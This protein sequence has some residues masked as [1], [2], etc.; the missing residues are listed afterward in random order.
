MKLLFTF[1]ALMSVLKMATAQTENTISINDM[2]KLGFAKYDSS[3]VGRKSGDVYVHRVFTLNTESKTDTV[4]AYVIHFLRPLENKLKNYQM[5][6][7][8]DDDYS[9]AG[10]SWV[11]DSIVSVTLVNP[12]TNNKQNVKLVQTS[13]KGCSAGILKESLNEK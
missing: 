1:I 13:C 6:L 5:T 4:N 8:I 9:N 11:S 3:T 10:Y 2:R 7:Q 12:I